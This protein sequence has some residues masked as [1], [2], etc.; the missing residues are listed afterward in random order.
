MFTLA[1]STQIIGTA[2]NDNILDL[3][4]PEK[5]KPSVV[6]MRMLLK[7]ITMS[8]F[9]EN[10]MFVKLEDQILLSFGVGRKR[11]WLKRCSSISKC[12]RAVF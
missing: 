3:Q 4:I 1:Y 2:T 10:R 9:A 7:K 6:P 5:P 11:A 8:G 12:P